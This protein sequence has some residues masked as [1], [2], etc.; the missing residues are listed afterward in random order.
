MA[1]FSADALFSVNADL[2][3]G[4]VFFV[5]LLLFFGGLGSS[6]LMDVN[7]KLPIFF[8]AFVRHW[9]GLFCFGE[10]LATGL[11]GVLFLIGVVLLEQGE[12]LIL[13]GVEAFFFVPD[14]LLIFL[15][16]ALGG[17]ALSDLRAEEL[18][19]R[20]LASGEEL[21][22]TLLLLATGVLEFL[23][24]LLFFGPGP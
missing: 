10:L 12:I 16:F 15:L 19:F 9:Q 6:I 20:F 3:F 13:P 14:D 24:L 5:G 21:E 4:G 2:F 8:G 7:L 1:F 18:R 17:E 23:L 22:P 11:A